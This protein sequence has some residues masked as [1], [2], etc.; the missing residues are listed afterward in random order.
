MKFSNFQG[1]STDLAFTYYADPA[2][3]DPVEPLLLVQQNCNPKM[4]F[5][6]SIKV[7]GVSLL[8]G[9]YIFFIYLDQSVSHQYH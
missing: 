7:D 1:T 3:L 4:S 8:K 6:L 2:F 9:I 5:P